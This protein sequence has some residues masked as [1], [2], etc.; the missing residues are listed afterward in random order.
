LQFGQHKRD[1][2]LQYCLDCDA[3]F[4][5]SGEHFEDQAARFKAMMACQ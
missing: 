2:L 1:A 4:N 3:R 5:L